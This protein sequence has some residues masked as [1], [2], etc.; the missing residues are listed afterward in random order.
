MFASQDSG[1]V[2][3]VLGLL[4][5]I[6]VIISAIINKLGKDDGSASQ[7]SVT[8]EISQLPPRVNQARKI[9]R[10]LSELLPKQFIVL[11]LE[12]TGLSP[13]TDEIIEIGAIKVTLGDER[14]LAMQ[15]LV[16][17]T[18]KLPPIITRITGITQ[19]MIDADGIELESAMRQFMEFV[20]DLPLVTYNAEFDIG[21]L[22]VAAWQCG[23]V[24][25]NSYTCALKLARRAWPGLPNHKLVTVASVFNLPDN[26]QHRAL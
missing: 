10:D 11:D 2:G 8:P 21:F 5:I 6:A 12:T 1:I 20:G 24:L 4:G 22:T 18:R 19:A 25:E 16:K 15:T 17:P 7:P 3:V 14:H 23:L 26:D 9:Q 13:T